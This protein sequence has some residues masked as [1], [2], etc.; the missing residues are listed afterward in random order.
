MQPQLGVRVLLYCLCNL[1][2][3]WGGWLTPRIGSFRARSKP[4][5]TRA[6]IRFRL[7]SERTSPFKL[8]GVSL[9]STAGSRGVRISVSNAGY[10]TF[11]GLQVQHP[12]CVQRIVCFFLLC[13]RH[14]NLNMA[15]QGR[16]M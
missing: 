7:P 3:R 9:Q 14:C 1:V 5:G 6:E 16:I 2:A 4:G 8:A 12:R 11:L 10:T 13:E 15:E